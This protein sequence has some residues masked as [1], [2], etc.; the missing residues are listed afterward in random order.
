MRE[1]GYFYFFVLHKKY[2]HKYRTCTMVSRD[3]AIKWSRVEVAEQ[4]KGVRAAPKASVQG[5][6]A[7]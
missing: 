3:S 2:P 7:H 5:G 1:L 6:A 4:K